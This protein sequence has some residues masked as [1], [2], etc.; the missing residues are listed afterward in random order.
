MK[1]TYNDCNFTGGYVYVRIMGVGVWEG[2]GGEHV[3][4]VTARG[5]IGSK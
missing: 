1:I 5:N 4:I 2:R 3:P